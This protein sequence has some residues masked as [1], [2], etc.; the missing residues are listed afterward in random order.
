MFEYSCHY[1]T[2]SPTGYNIICNE[3]NDIA[4]ANNIIHTARIL[5][6]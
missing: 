1:Y 5:T 3:Y 6:L 4:N 2:Y